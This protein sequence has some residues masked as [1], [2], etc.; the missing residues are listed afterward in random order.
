MGNRKN[1]FTWAWPLISLKWVPEILLSF[2]NLIEPS[3]IGLQ[4]EMTV[5]VANKSFSNQLFRQLQILLK[6]S[7]LVTEKGKYISASVKP[8]YESVRLHLI[9]FV[10]ESSAL[11]AD[12]YNL[13]SEKKYLLSFPQIKN[14]P[15]R[16]WIEIAS[17][18]VFKQWCDFF[19]YIGFG[20]LLNYDLFIPESAITTEMRQD[21]KFVEK[22]LKATGDPRYL[23]GNDSLHTGNDFLAWTKGE[24]CLPVSDNATL[25]PRISYATIIYEWEKNK[26]EL[27]SWRLALLKSVDEWHQSIHEL[28]SDYPVSNLDSVVHSCKQFLDYFLFGKS[29]FDNDF[30]DQEKIHKIKKKWVSVK[31]FVMSEQI[32]KFLPNL[33]R[34]ITRLYWGVSHYRNSLRKPSFNKNFYDER[35]FKY[36][37]INLDKSIS[38]KCFR[39]R[40]TLQAILKTLSTI[41]TTL[42][43]LIDNQID[44]YYQNQTQKMYYNINDYL[45]SNPLEIH[46]LF[47]ALE[48]FIDLDPEEKIHL[49]KIPEIDINTGYP[50]TPILQ[51]CFW[52]YKYNEFNETPYIATVKSIQSRIEKI[53]KRLIYEIEEYSHYLENWKI[54]CN[55]LKKKV[56]KLRPVQK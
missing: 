6:E 41:Y 27:G 3:W 5:H 18:T 32:W 51:T 48:E 10:N 33:Y 42:S 55:L 34:D 49:L 20:F 45:P 24:N 21:I 14:H 12:Y 50:N 15:P 29:V 30:L 44:E 25:I 23:T 13:I 38:L 7:C 11:W 46:E 43:R 53:E 56:S 26:Q 9:N 35:I 1:Q 39:S 28:L 17:Y 37:K 52:V 4:R 16:A 47:N 54:A 40:R 19:Q 22:C 8:D 2:N 36:N 31:F